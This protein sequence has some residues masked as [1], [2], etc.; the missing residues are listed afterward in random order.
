MTACTLRPISSADLE[1][2]HQVYASTREAELRQVDWSAEQK[3][4][5]TRMQFNAQH[6]YYSANYLNPSFQ[7]V[8]CEGVPA[9]RLYLDRRADEIRIVDITLLPQFRGQ[10]LGTELLAQVLAEGQLR[11]LPVTIHVEVFNPALR[12]YE[13]LGFR[14]VQ[15]KG[16]YYFMRWLPEP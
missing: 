6:T 4:A 3:E 10:G 16:V 15:D 14:Q 2:L 13:R 7:I 9:G 11:G 1:F 5:F 8:E 12:L